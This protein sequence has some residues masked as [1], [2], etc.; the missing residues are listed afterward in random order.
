[1]PRPR[2]R[3]L[4]GTTTLVTLRRGLLDDTYLGG[5][6]RAASTSS[7]YRS[8]YGLSS[9]SDCPVR[10]TSC[11]SPACRV[12][13]AAAESRLQPPCGEKQLP[14]LPE[15]QHQT[16]NSSR[17]VQK[18]ALIRRPDRPCG[19]SV[20]V[21][22]HREAKPEPYLS[23]SGRYPRPHRQRKTTYLRAQYSVSYPTEPMPAPTRPP[24]DM[25]NR[26]PFLHSLATMDS[27]R[28]TREISCT[29]HPNIAV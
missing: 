1:M 23:R 25:A 19:T 27:K 28:L 24:P 5:K 14:K 3:R 11:P 15:P 12:Q 26:L 9:A 4:H 20:R 7:C 17:I 10:H 16:G 2:A 21:P 6:H 8:A 22:F 13:D 18:A 29:K